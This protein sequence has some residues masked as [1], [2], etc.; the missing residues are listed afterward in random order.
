MIGNNEFQV[1]R[2]GE[3]KENNIEDVIPKLLPDS[4]DALIHRNCLFLDESFNPRDEKPDPRLTSDIRKR[5]GY[6]VAIVVFKYG[7]YKFG[8][9]GGWQREQAGIEIGYTVFPCKIFDNRRKM[10]EYL[11]SSYLQTPLSNLANIRNIMIH[12]R[13]FNDINVVAQKLSKSIST[14]KRAVKINKHF[15]L[16]S[17]VAKPHERDVDNWRFIY[18]IEGRDMF[19]KRSLTLEI[20]E[21]LAL[22]LHKFSE[23]SIGKIAILLFK[24]KKSYNGK[25]DRIIDYIVSKPDR[26]DY[27]VLIAEFMN[28]KKK[29]NITMNLASFTLDERELLEK[30]KGEMRV[31]T[32]NELITRL[33]RRDLC[34]YN[35]SFIG[36]PNKPFKDLRFKYGTQEIIIRKNDGD[37]EVAILGDD[38][39]FIK[40]QLNDVL[41][42]RWNSNTLIHKPIKAILNTLKIKY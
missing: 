24:N 30:Y 34:L 39:F 38:G 6:Q 9:G 5:G 35:S 28:I 37:T 42:K 32:I 36:R 40:Y 18:D 22:G 10:L 33:I 3:N 26:D 15:S 14:I 21:S 7:E 13:E 25:I 20:A 19:E 11:D 1:I 31:K 17:L 27:K 41:E 8:V 12:Y 4:Y 29:Q 2:N 23:N 16:L